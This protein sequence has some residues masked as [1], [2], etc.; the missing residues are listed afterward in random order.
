MECIR[1]DVKSGDRVIGSYITDPNTPPDRRIE[2]DVGD[3]SWVARPEF[4]AL[5]A[6]KNAEIRR[7]KAA[8]A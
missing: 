1:V 8:T 4:E 6:E 3:V 7:L 2:F 5:I